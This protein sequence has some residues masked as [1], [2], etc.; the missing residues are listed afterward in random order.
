MGAGPQLPAVTALHEGREIRFVHP[1]ASDPAV[2]KVLTDMMGGSPVM[3]VPELAQV[4][5]SALAN[6]FVFRNGVRGGG[7]FGFQPDVFA[8]VPGAADYS[9]LRAVNLVRWR[10]PAGA[11]PAL[12]GRGQ[13]SGKTRRGRGREKRHRRQH[14]GDQVAVGTALRARWSGLFASREPLLGGSPPT[15]PAAGGCDG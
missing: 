14:A 15:S 6:V 11:Y 1:E 7:P 4:P 8:S 10:D 9:P 2:A 12:G 5:R 3:V 13:G